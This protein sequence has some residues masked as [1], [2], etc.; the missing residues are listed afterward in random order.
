MQDQNWN[1]NVNLGG[2]SAA[3]GRITVVE[4]YYN[5]TVTE[6]Y[7]DAARN[8]NRVVFKVTFTDPGFQGVVRTGGLNVPGSTKNDNRAFWRA[9]ME[10]CGYPP[11]QLDQNLNLSANAVIG[12]PCKVYFRPRDEN[13]LDN[14]GRY[15]KLDF[16]SP[17]DWDLRKT[18]HASRKAAPA[19]NTTVQ[20]AAPVAAAP[21]A[22]TLGTPSIPTNGGG[23]PAPSASFAHPGNVSVDELRQMANV[24]RANN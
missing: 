19:Q 11:A 13:A 22:P 7:I 5:A 18:S 23:I 16:L 12:R 10:S 14:D 2:V 21:S 4:G 6:A 20:H 17:K 24:G 9:L 8:S 1:F 15:D 3:G